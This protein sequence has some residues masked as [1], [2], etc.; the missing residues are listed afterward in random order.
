MAKANLTDL[1]A[2]L[3]R[4]T[5]PEQIAEILAL[6][7]DS[8][9]IGLDEELGDS[10]LMWH[11]VGDDPGNLSAINLATKPGRSLTERITN[12][13]DAMLEKRAHSVSAPYPKNPREATQQWFGRPATGRDQGLYTWDYS[14]NHD[15]KHIHVTLLESGRE[16]AP[17]VDVLDSGIGIGP[18]NFA[19]TILSLRG[20]N[21]ISKFYLVGAFGQGG[22]STLAFSEYALYAS[23]HVDDPAILTFTLIRVLRLSDAYKEDCYVYLTAVAEDGAAHMPSINTGDAALDIYDAPSVKAP[24]WHHGTLVRHIGF[25]LSGLNAT[26]GPSPGNL[27][28]YLHATLFDPLLPFR[29]L[30]LRRP[31]S[32]KNELV[33]GS[34]NRLMN[35]TTKKLD[36]GEHATT[37]LKHYKPMEFVVPHGETDASLG[38]EYWVV[39]NWKKAP[40]GSKM[41]RTL[42]PSSNEL[43]I[44]HNYPV[45]GTQNGQN[46][47][48]LSSAMFRRLNLPMVGRHIIIHVDASRAPS[49]VR[50]M[51]FSSTRE[52]FKDGPILTGIERVLST[53]MDD[54]KELSSIERELAE[55]LVQR[56]NK[57]TEDEVKSQI[58]KLLLDSGVAVHEEGKTAQP[59]T[60]GNEPT[61]KKKRAP[62]KN[63]EPL[64]TLPFPQVTEWKIVVP[65]ADLE[66]RIG[67]YETV[68]VETNADAEFDRR[69]AVAIRAEPPIVEVGTKAPLSGGRVR[70][71]MRATEAAAHAQEGRI[72]ATITRPD[73]SQLTS[74]R[75]FVILAKAPEPAK[76]SKGSVPPFEVLPIDPTKGE[77]REQWGQLWPTLADSQDM[78]ELSS[79]AYR[80]SAIGSKRYVYFNTLFTPFRATEDSYLVK[81]KGLAELFR[82]QYK[83]WIG[84]HALLQEAESADERAAT[85][86]DY[87]ERVLE[88]ET[89]RVATMQ[90]KQAAQFVELKRAVMKVSEEILA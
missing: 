19:R 17:T 69:N 60:N 42:R 1:F 64:P 15:D 25:K 47:G 54:D 71:R 72:I 58:T 77:D 68:L 22:S 37:E 12:A 41:E 83:V 24:L 7:G 49:H 51:L 78:L 66:V 62:Y 40:K 36:D 18:D 44:Q 48:E 20:G 61:D 45:L 10:G 56:E 32:L 3:I 46:Q 53:M 57:K 70:W 67:D 90:A 26:L 2:E 23:R 33:S 84:Y 59:G 50:R 27:Y 34:R 87:V 11:A 16:D 39:L 14:T 35:Y 74:E 73:G 88:E 29:L 76:P 5:R 75:R 31:A 21:K 38:V 79:V 55:R 9:E 30:D 89:V 28:H 63:K 82:V 13:I 81:G 80:V 52:G 4:A 43:F 85:T 65:S 6:L 8:T 86:E